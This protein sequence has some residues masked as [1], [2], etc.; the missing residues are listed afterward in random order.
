MQ[1][2][3]NTQHPIC[4]DLKIKLNLSGGPLWDLQSQG[5][6]LIRPQASL[7][8]QDSNFSHWVSV[9]CP[10]PAYIRTGHM[11]RAETA[12]CRQISVH[13]Q[14]LICI[15]SSMLSVAVRVPDGSLW[16]SAWLNWNYW[17]ITVHLWSRERRCFQKD[18]TGEELDW[19]ASSHSLGSQDK[20]KGKRREPAKCQHSS[21]CLLFYTGVR[22]P[23][24]M[25]LQL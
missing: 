7:V 10:C 19:A 13:D 14:R 23:G 3:T 5:S 20:K 16:L 24:Y 1:V 9:A 21:L 18:L 8:L 4:Q 12:P 22:S 17:G 11:S 15:A 25:L 6:G 2:Y